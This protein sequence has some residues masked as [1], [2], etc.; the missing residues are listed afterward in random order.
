MA[1]WCEGRQFLKICVPNCTKKKYR[2]ENGEK[3]SYLR[4]PDDIILK[5]VGFM[6]FLETKEKRLESTKHEDLFSSF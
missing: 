5:N 6:P 1:A 4:F 3:I 2:T